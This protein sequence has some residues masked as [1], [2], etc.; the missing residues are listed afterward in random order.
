MLVPPSYGP[1]LGL[2]SVI[3]R[4]ER[5]ERLVTGAGRNAF[6]PI[7]LEWNPTCKGR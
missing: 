6:L 2:K 4:A 5:R 3:Y 1:D 7:R